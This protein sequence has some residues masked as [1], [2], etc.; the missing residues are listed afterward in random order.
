MDDFKQQ[1]NNLVEE[2]KVSM[3]SSLDS[4]KG[5][6]MKDKRL[7]GIGLT[8]AVAILSVFVAVFSYRNIGRPITPSAPESKPEAASQSCY[9]ELSIRTPSPSPSLQCGA[10]CPNQSN[11][12]GAGLSC[13]NGICRNPSCSTSANCICSTRTPT[14]RSS[15]TPIP[16]PTGSCTTVT[17]YDPPH[18]ICSVNGTTGAGFWEWR[19]ILEATQYEV[20]IYRADGTIFLNNDWQ[21]S[22]VFMNCAIGKCSYITSNMPLGSYYSRIRARNLGVCRESNWHQSITIT[23]SRCG[24]TPS[25]TIKP[26]T[27]RPT[28]RPTTCP[29]YQGILGLCR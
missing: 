26:P 22:E 19:H 8:V 25:P 27:P 7:V 29:W 12:C 18:G 3:D 10:T 28:P 20:D 1:P 21:S 15:P 2:P 11:G 5:V 23:V 6:S 4:T 9:L 13:I 24:P 14:P 17:P 16:T